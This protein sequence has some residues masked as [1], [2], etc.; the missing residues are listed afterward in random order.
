MRITTGTMMSHYKRSLNTTLNAKN[1]AYQKVTTGRRFSKGS[2][3]PAEAARAFE[4]RRSYLKNDDYL[5]NLENAKDRFT[6]VESSMMG[7]SKL[8]EDVY[9]SNISTAGGKSVT[10]REIISAS[11]KEIQQ[12]MV[13]EANAKFGDDFLFSGTSNSLPFELSADGKTLTYRGI[14]VSTTDPAEMA[15]LKELA[16]EKVYTDLGFGM[17]FGADGKVVDSSVYN[18]ATPGIEFL[19]Y[20][21]DADGSP[22]NM[23]VLL[24]QLAEAVKEPVL[25]EAKFDSLTNKFNDARQVISNN[26]TKLGTGTK[27]LET[28]QKRL[29]DTKYNLNE[30]I[31]KNEFIELPEAMLD[32]SW[33]EYAYNAAIKV[34]TGII[35]QSLIDFMR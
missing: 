9:V 22:K 11:L 16:G 2:E 28:T 27:F 19:G 7:I 32:Y 20:G 13:R 1:L 18:T 17:E 33:A 5:N 8:G 29:E 26:I 15:K 4:L 6:M 34:G 30:Q 31:H 35:S 21:T 12:S 14:D 3:S 25:D 23:I 24:G 10:E